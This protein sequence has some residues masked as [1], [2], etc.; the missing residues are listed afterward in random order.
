LL[1]AL[2]AVA[3]L[4]LPAQPQNADT[5]W[6]PWLGCWQPVAQAG[7]PA[8]LLV[9]VSPQ[10]GGSGVEIATVTGGR[11]VS[12]RALNADGQRHTLA[13]EGCT[14]WQSA[15]FSADGRRAYL[16][17]ESTCEGGVQ[18]SASAI[19]SITA[20]SEWLDAQSLGTGTDRVARILRY[21]PAS[22]AMVREAGQEPP[23][24]ERIV[25]IMDARLMAATEL[26]LADVQEAAPLVDGDA[27]EAFLIERNQKFDVDAKQAL[28]LADAGVPERVIDVLVAL[29]YPN[30]F[31]ID[32]E[33]MKAEAKPMERNARDR[34]A[35]DYDPYGWGW[36]GGRYNS[37]CW[38][39][40]YSWRSACDPFYY[41][42]GYGSGYGFGIYDPW[43]FGYWN[44][45][46]IIVRGDGEEAPHGRVVNGR[47]YTRGSSSSGTSTGGTVRRA[48]P[49]EEGS[50]SSAGRSSGSSGGGRATAGGYTRGTG[51]SS[52]GSGASS[53]AST[54]GGSSGGSSGRSA[55]TRGG[56]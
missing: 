21:V 34:Y 14:G 1:A 28:A 50:V 18:R 6:L 43:Y 17:T 25:Q 23:A 4:P 9:C 13:E 15:Q 5:R 31:A 20:G 38:D 12:T 56:G 45:P 49:S 27:L 37:R 48:R 40:F 30:Y 32:R 26:S 54:S 53:G 22:E 46:I 16:R 19:M 29:S 10:A 44:R 2:L 7:A 39:S 8:D 42:Y 51:S 35:G 24:A 47:G 55:K 3:L 52:G 36:Y 33:G 41:G 11:T